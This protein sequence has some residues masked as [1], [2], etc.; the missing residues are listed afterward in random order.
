MEEDDG[1]L[2]DRVHDLSDLELAVLLSLVSHGHCVI[3]TP[4]G[5]VE[6]LV[7]ELGLIS[8]R[9]FGLRHAVAECHADTTLEDFARSLLLAVRPSP[10]AGNNSASAGSHQNGKDHQFHG[11]KAADYFHLSPAAPQMSRSSG[12]RSPHS[13][14]GLSAT[15]MASSSATSSAT[16]PAGALC[17]AN[18][19]IA[20][21]LNLAPEVVQIQALELMR[22]QRIFTSTVMQAA[23]RPFLL[24]AVVAAKRRFLW[25]GGDCTVKDSS[26]GNG[27]KAAGRAPHMTAHLNDHF[28]IGH[29]HDPDDGFPNIEEQDEDGGDERHGEASSDSDSV[30]RRS[31]SGVSS[32]S[33]ASDQPRDQELL[34]SFSEEDIDH[35][36][37]LSENVRIDMEV[38]RYQMNIV[39]FLRLHRAVA[40]IGPAASGLSCVSPDATKHFEKLAQCLA[41][42]HRLEYVTPALVALA[43]RKTYL[44]RIRTVPVGHKGCRPATVHERSMQWGSEKA[45]VEALLEGISPEDVIDDVLGSVAPPV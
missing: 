22:N 15:G 14:A 9:I 27:G 30:V 32:H 29:W 43:A 1:D 35:L 6:E 4:E 24:V 44:H 39:A 37:A 31:E 3:G 17:M 2:V 7:E 11:S 19:V 28:S 20:K 12:V 36:A 34:P 10:V 33:R 23:P 42:L 26:H 18:V 21:N 8:Q 40:V 13:P 25:N 41:P 45:A 38:L 16:T 5:S